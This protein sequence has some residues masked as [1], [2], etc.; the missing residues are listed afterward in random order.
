MNRPKPQFHVFGGRT[1]MDDI[2]LNAPLGLNADNDE[3]P[4]PQLSRRALLSGGAA[5]CL[6]GAASACGPVGRG[7]SQTGAEVDPGT[8][9]QCEKMLDLAYTA[10]ERAQILTTF[11]DQ[12]DTIRAVHAFD[13]ENTLA[14]ALVFD[15]RLPGRTYAEQSGGVR[16]AANASLEAP[17]NLVDLVFAPAS[18]Q[19]HW[20]RTK[21]IS[22]REL[23]QAY[24]D[25]IAQYNPLLFNYITVTGE[26]AL[27]QADRADQ[28]TAAGINRGSL[29]GIPYGVKDLIDTAGIRTTWGATPYRD[30]VAQRNAWIIDKLE[31]AGA[32]LLGK[33]TTGALAYSDQWFGGRTRNPWNPN[34]GSTGS[35]AGSAAAT[36]AGMCGFAIGTETVGSVV[37]PSSRC[38]VVGLRPTFGRIPRTGTM[39]LCW[40]L[41]KIGAICRSVADI[42]NV[43]EAIN[44]QDPGDPS[45]LGHGFEWDARDSVDGMRVGYMPGWFEDAAA[46]DKAALAAISAMPVDLVELALPDLPYNTLFNAVEIEAAAAFHELTSSNRDDEMVWQADRAWPNTFRRVH[47]YS[48]VDFVQVDRFRR[49]IMGMMDKLM[50]GLDAIISPVFSNPLLGDPLLM[51]TTFTGHPCLTLRAGF[52]EI[53]TRIVGDLEGDVL[54]SELHTVPKNVMLWGPLFEE[55]KLLTLGLALE[56][57]MNVGHIRPPLET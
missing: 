48:A 3:S 28:E 33:T 35:S 51:I 11:D 34:E 39:A 27:E 38:G 30:R 9:S 43:L 36:A 16:G 2:S 45:S 4:G 10:D 40:S 54:D 49:K 26:L 18:A 46:P 47:F 42:A 23:T 21:K 32:V 57:A 53:A 24:L 12:L 8:V 19:A 6:A 25:R 41:D 17:A 44:G 5:A 14:P 55:R 37:G 20:I 15:P 52:V 22:S 50:T 29:H 13:F 7:A 31:Q 56:K 1:V